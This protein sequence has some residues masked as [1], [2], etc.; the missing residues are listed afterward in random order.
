[1]VTETKR[2]LKKSQELFEEAKNLLPT[3]TQ[4]L[5][6][7]YTQWVQG[8]APIYVE[9]AKGAYITDVDGNTLI[10]YG[11]G[12]GPMILGY[13]NPTV[14]AAIREQ[15]DKGITF[16]LPH[17]LE[18]DLAKMLVDII[19]CAEMVKYGKNGSDAT[20]AA[21]KLA[22]AHTGRDL[23]VTCGYHG[24]QDWFIGTTERNRGI[25]EAVRKLT[26]KFEYN[27]INGL[28]KVLEENKG[29]IAAVMMEPVAMTLP[30]EGFLEKVKEL[31]HNAGAV[32]IYDE[33][34][35]GFRV[36][37]GGAQEYF[38]VTPDLAAFGKAVSNGM[39]LSMV[40]GKKEIMKEFEDTPERK[41]VFS[42]FTYG[43]EALSLA[44]AIATL[45]FMKEH[46]VIDYNWKQGR[47]IQEGIR[48]LAKKHD[49]TDV[50]SSEGLPPK[51]FLVLSDPNK[52]Y[53]PLELKS[54]FQQEAIRRGVLF[55]GYHAVSYAHDD[56]VVQKTLEAYDGAMGELKKALNQ[57][58]LLER[59]EG[60]VLTQIFQ[61]VGDR[62][63]IKKD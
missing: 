7:G 15:L 44:A 14:D 19:P 11:M 48:S 34:F 36:A 29:K 3:Q 56:A 47:K 30:K 2:N 45:K 61:N 59:L 41:G 38:G 57:G 5:S 31:T 22:R 25:P 51:N 62:W 39:P 35:T 28:E 32:L 16:T 18:V 20:S 54:F 53:S 49:L 10:D 42:S 58:N 8:V 43:G 6:K 24:W 37:L 9:S 1:M 27:D 40:V 46:N 17:R 12:L 33:V 63:G 52:K 26:L 13:G 4:T 55:I 60:P 21:I 23:V 50:V